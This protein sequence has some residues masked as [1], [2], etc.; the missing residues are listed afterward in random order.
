[1]IAEK[2]RLS[3][4]FTN[5]SGKRACATQIY[6]AGVSEQE[7]TFIRTGHCSVAVRKYKDCTHSIF[8]KISQVFDPPIWSEKGR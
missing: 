1:M 2:G 3:G 7:S 8:K 6:I 5:H 4:N